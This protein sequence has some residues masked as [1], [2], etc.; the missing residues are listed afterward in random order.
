MR[1]KI[2]KIQ[3]NSQIIQEVTQLSCLH[4]EMDQKEKRK[5]LVR[6]YPQSLSLKT[7]NQV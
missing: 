5:G 6:D 3:L 1:Q 7:K 2:D 4:L